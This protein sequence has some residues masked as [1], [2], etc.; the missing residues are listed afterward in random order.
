MKALGLMVLEKKNFK[1]F[2]IYFYVKLLTP[3]A[4]PF[5]TPGGF[6]QQY[7]WTTSRCWNIQNMKALGLLVSE[8]KI[9]KSFPIYFNVKTFDPWGGA[10]FDPRGILSTIYVKDL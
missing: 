10:I 7:M 4:G 3:G 8:K 1:S 6:L 2:P 5:L 9:F